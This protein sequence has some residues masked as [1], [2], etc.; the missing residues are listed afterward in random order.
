MTALHTL[1]ALTYPVLIYLALGVASPR[2]VA[3]CALALLAARLSLVAPARLV[4]VVR[5]ARLPALAFAG[6]NL[7]SALWNNAAS[8]LL[9]PAL[10]SFALLL[11][12]GLSFR[13][14]ETVI[15]T[16]ARD[17]LG[18]LA[19]EERAYCRKVTALWCAFFF[20]TGCAAQS[21]L[22]ARTGAL[23]GVHRTSSGTAVR[24]E[25][26]YRQWRFRR[27]MGAPTDAVRGSFPRTLP[28]RR[29]E[30]EAPW[31]SATARVA[32]DCQARSEGAEDLV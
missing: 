27:Y 31:R 5:L 32:V 2:V 15:E 17:Q 9:T 21:W 4:T 24:L 8:L 19:P 1:L 26:V 13:Q 25:F 28:E 14:P 20:G 30:L 23:H 10:V 12:F 6:A 11:A 22:P 3:L 18:T 16:F 29:A 7:A